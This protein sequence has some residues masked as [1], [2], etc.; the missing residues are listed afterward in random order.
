M[1]RAPNPEV[2]RRT[3]IDE[4]HVTNSIDSVELIDYGF[5]CTYSER[6]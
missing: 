4:M 2:Y 5:D 6:Y 3:V 1:D